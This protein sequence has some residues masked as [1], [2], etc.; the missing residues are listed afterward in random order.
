MDINLHSLIA[1]LN[2]TCRQSLEE[3]AGLCLTR[4]HYQVTVE[5]WLLKLLAA[6]QTDLIAICNYYAVDITHLTTELMAKLDSQKAG[7]TQVAGLSA[8]LLQIIREA[9]LL[10]SLEFNASQIRSGYLLYALLA[11]QSLTYAGPSLPAELAKIKLDS[12]R[13]ELSHLLATSDETVQLAATSIVDATARP[14]NTKTP[15]LE[16]FTLDL[17]AQARQGKIDP[18]VGREP[19]IRQ[20][21][22]ILTRRR[23]NNPILTGEAGVGKTA[24]VEGFALRIASHDVP[25]SLQNVMLRTLDLTLL[26]AG[27]SMKGEFE[28]RLKGIIEEVKASPQPIIL[29][30][31]EAH[32]LIGNTGQSDAAN[33][34]KPALARGELRTIAA[35]TWAE[36]KKYFE[37]DAALTRRFQVVQIEEPAEDNAIAMLRGIVASLEKHHGVMILDEAIMDAVKLSKRY[38]PGRKL[39]DKAVSLLDTACARL[40]V[41]QQAIPASIENLQQQIQRLTAKITLLMR[42]QT[43]TGEIDEQLPTL[44]AEKNQYE[45]QLQKLHER[46][47]QEK[48]VVTQICQLRNQLAQASTSALDNDLRTQQQAE[49]KQLSQQLE[50]LQDDAPMLQ[51][52][53]DKHIVAQVVAELTGIPVGRMVAN[54]IQA[55]LTLKDKLNER[56]VGQTHA[57]EAI[58]QHIRTSR[59]K[60]AD[61]RKPIGVFLMVGSSGVGKTET[62][63]ALAEQ[64]YGNEQNMIVLN[65]SEYKEE[66]KVSTLMGSPP[67]YVG[68]G[69]GGVLTEA[70]RR[71]PYSIILLDEMEKA[72]PGIQDVFYQVFD[73]GM[74]R[75]SEGRDVDFKNTVIIM[76]SN[77]GTHTIHK[78][79]NNPSSLP[80][81]EQLGEALRPELLHYFKPAFLGRVSL[82][83]YLPLSE[84]VLRAIIKLQL[85][86]LK[87][88]VSQNYQAQ[89]SYTERVIDH[90]AAR[91]QE[92]ETGARNVDHILTRSVLPDLATEFLTRMAHGERI[93]AVTVDV[94]ANEKFTY[95]VE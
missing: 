60:L 19:E 13:H 53:V 69:E 27:A 78:L 84:S 74:L 45:E 25:N 20:L 55:I 73:K 36:Y 70:V 49:L 91:C 6:P 95:Q 38:I 17:T 31:D 2:T 63:L 24:V 75:D 16:R 61:P 8:Q 9:W 77:A 39:P 64:L 35:T 1:R 15:H 42:E 51:A 48:H 92:V 30:I 81:L 29:F 32:T 26:Q 28:N 83:P 88:R 21:V 86:R 82:V 57:L 10:T 52:Y 65:M 14:V 22:D 46:W 37:R 11:E 71:R 18:V 80:D 85:E 43:I 40:A 68:Y 34:L 66:H 56:I 41:N 23:Q 59:A 3:A 87:Q 72:H 54:E 33:L 4:G 79:A 12:L 76:T 89:C 94:A 90:I 7:N 44:S 58:A 67:G 5:H 93:T 62:A 50:S 47:Q